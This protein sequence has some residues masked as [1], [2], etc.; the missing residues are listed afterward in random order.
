M[1][2]GMVTHSPTAARSIPAELL[3]RQIQALD[4]THVLNVP[5]T[6]QKTLLALLAQQERPRLV[7]TCTEDEALAI[8]AGLYI[9]GQ[10]PM[11]SIQNTG[12]CACMNSMRGVLLEGRVPALLLIG[13]LHRELDKHPN[14]SQVLTNRLTIPTLEAWNIPHYLLEN[15]DDLPFIPEAY[16]RSFDE[17]GPVVVLVGAKTA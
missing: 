2:A 11:L 16:Q 3:L 8:H 15:E 17:R 5:D 1:M 6:H 13:L 9:G 10:R 14:D 7:T 12:L 4:V